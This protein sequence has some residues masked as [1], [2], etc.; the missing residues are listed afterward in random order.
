MLGDIWN[1]IKPENITTLKNYGMLQIQYKSTWITNNRNN[2][3]YRNLRKFHFNFLF[4]FFTL[5]ALKIW[6][7]NDV[8]SKWSLTEGTLESLFGQPFVGRWF[9]FKFVE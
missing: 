4:F 1:T 3:H 9:I 5:D 6:A 7:Q 8:Y 2:K